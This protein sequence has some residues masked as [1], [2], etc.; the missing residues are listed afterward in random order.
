LAWAATPPGAPGIGFLRA[1]GVE[2]MWSRATEGKLDINP[3]DRSLVMILS[4]QRTVPVLVEVVGC[5]SQDDDILE[6]ISTL[7]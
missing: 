7:N 1:A 2:G 6:Y 5:Q 4:G 3:S